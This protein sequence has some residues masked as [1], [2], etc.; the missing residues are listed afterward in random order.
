MAYINKP[1]WMPCTLFER[2][3]RED[4][5]FRLREN[6]HK[7]DTQQNFIKHTLWSN[8]TWRPG[9][10]WA[11]N[12]QTFCQV[13]QTAAEKQELPQISVIIWEAAALPSLRSAS[14]WLWA[15]QLWAAE[16]ILTKMVSMQHPGLLWCCH[17]AFPLKK[18]TKW[19]PRLS[20]L[21]WQL[22]FAFR[23]PKTNFTRWKMEKPPSQLAR[24][25]IPYCR[26]VF[27]LRTLFCCFSF[28]IEFLFNQNFF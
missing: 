23:R 28:L 8:S 3:V 18:I 19:H 27:P 16:N 6:S 15:Q 11:R 9:C 26:R 4:V 5:T 24:T 13:M 25:E 7:K 22:P 20:I 2:P 21:V 12:R 1:S 10:S 14:F 17:Q